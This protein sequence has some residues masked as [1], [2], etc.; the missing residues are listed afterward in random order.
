[1]NAEAILRKAVE[2]IGEGDC[3]CECCQ[4]SRF[5][6]AMA[7]NAADELYFIRVAIPP[8]EQH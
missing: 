7:L 4:K 3:E 5:T 2:E 1:M 8:D 6:A